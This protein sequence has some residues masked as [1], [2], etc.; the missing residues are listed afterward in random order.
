MMHG[1]TVDAGARAS[2]W[3][4]AIVQ[5]VRMKLSPFLFIFDFGTPRL[6]LCPDGHTFCACSAQNGYTYRTVPH[7]NRRVLFESKNILPFDS[8][9]VITVCAGGSGKE[10][11]SVRGP[12]E[13][14]NL[15]LGPPQT[16]IMHCSCKSY[17]DLEGV[18]K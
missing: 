7:T 17:H 12:N 14:I 15:E 4:L 2:A 3:A 13:V 16:H 11:Q 6:L 18:R 8:F 9:S 10:I 5:S 1:R